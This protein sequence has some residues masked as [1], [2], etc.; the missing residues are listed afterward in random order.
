MYNPHW[1]EELNK[2]EQKNMENIRLITGKEAIT[3][4]DDVLYINE[5]RTQ[6]QDEILAFLKLIEKDLDRLERLEKIIKENFGY[7]ENTKECFFNYDAPVMEEEIKEAL[8]Y[9]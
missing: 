3:R 7:N 9:E 4:I 2:K 1:Q 5:V 6:V 8:G